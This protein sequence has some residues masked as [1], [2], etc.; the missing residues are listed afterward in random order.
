MS[1]DKYDRTLVLLIDETIDKMYE[2][3]LKG[4]KEGDDREWKGIKVKND[5]KFDKFLK[6]MKMVIIRNQMFS[7]ILN[8]S[9]SSI[10]HFQMHADGIV[11]IVFKS[12]DNIIR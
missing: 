9:H 3:Y 4:I 2:G 12:V 1:I 10:H 6:G 8:G 7:P 11:S 5:L